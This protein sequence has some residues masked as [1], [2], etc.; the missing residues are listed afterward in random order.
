MSWR[1]SCVAAFV[2][3]LAAARPC[4]FNQSN[5]NRDGRCA[6]F[7][8]LEPV[9]VF[10]GSFEKMLC[11]WPDPAVKDPDQWQSAQAGRADPVNASVWAA[12]N[13]T[14]GLPA[15]IRSRLSPNP[16]QTCKG[17][18]DCCF[19]GAGLG[20]AMTDVYPVTGKFI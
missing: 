12:H 6:V 14:T 10:D 17:S 5:P 4:D 18:E 2:V 16:F 13:D 9:A 1:L 15:F 8:G 3:Q 7:V 19:R 11:Y 20:G